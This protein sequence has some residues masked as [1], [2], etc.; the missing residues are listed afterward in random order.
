MNTQSSQEREI[1][2]IKQEGKIIEGINEIITKNSLKLKTITNSLIAE[3]DE[4]TQRNN[5]L[6]QEKIFVANSMKKII[7]TNKEI[8]QEKI[9]SEKITKIVSKKEK[10]SKKKFKIAII[11]TLVLV[12]SLGIAIQTLEEINSENILV[13]ESLSNVTL[14]NIELES[15]L[16]T[17]E[18][19]IEQIIDDYNILEK[20]MFSDKIE[21]EDKILFQQKRMNQLIKEKGTV[22]ILSK[23]VVSQQIQINQLLQNMETSVI[24]SENPTISENINEKIK[25]T[26]TQNPNDDKIKIIIHTDQL[27]STLTKSEFNESVVK[28]YLTKILKDFY[29]DK[30]T[31]DEFS[32][33]TTFDYDNCDIRHENITNGEEIVMFCN[34]K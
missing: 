3:L 18:E 19:K 24:I 14:D 11:A 25:I 17:K 21:F 26:H 34:L 5:D 29:A 22:E 13:T 10:N 23:R 16:Q 2:E 6:E 9:I 33:L 32:Y 20:N 12:I 28:L 4:S 27:D 30:I 1:K 31:D 8:H 7:K 15:E